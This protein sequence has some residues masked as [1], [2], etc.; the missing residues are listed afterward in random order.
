MAAVDDS[1]LWIVVICNYSS[2]WVRIYWNGLY[3]SVFCKYNIFRGYWVIQVTLCLY[4]F[5]FYWFVLLEWYLRNLLIESKLKALPVRKYSSS[6]YWVSSVHF[7]YFYE[8]CMAWTLSVINIMNSLFTPQKSKIPSKI[9]VSIL[10][11]LIFLYNLFKNKDNLIARG[12][13]T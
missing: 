11:L 1:C 5:R 9:F 3:K 7:L 4:L 2:S 13:P 10:T 6:D 12:R 8:Y